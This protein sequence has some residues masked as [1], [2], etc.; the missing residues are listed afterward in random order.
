MRP[1]SFCNWVVSLTPPGLVVQ[2]VHLPAATRK[3]ANRT[4]PRTAADRPRRKQHV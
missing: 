3:A 4:W 2:V 1:G